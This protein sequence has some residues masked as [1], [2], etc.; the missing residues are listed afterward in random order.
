MLSYYFK[1]YELFN[2]E[3]S[4]NMA[5]ED[6]WLYQEMEEKC[7]VNDKDLMSMREESEKLKIQVEAAVEE[8]EAAQAALMEEERAVTGFQSDLKKKQHSVR[9]KYTYLGQL[10]D[11]SN[12]H[13][14]KIRWRS[15]SIENKK[16]ENLRLRHTVDN[17]TVTLEDKRRIETERR[18]L[19]ESLDMEQNYNDTY[20]KSVYADDLQLAKITN[21]S[22]NKAVAYS[23]TLIEY[24]NML[25]ALNL[26]NMPVNALHRDADKT[27]QVSTKMMECICLVHDTPL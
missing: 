22:K 21:E 4:D 26:L 19:E 8:G 13:L 27:M 24:S 16:A 10:E 12:K 15:E 1:C 11:I 17:Q 6:S 5:V 2:K 18:E 9:E 25:P 14:S 23:A 20:L 7:N 3:D